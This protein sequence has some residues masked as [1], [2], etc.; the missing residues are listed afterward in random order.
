VRPETTLQVNTYP[1]VEARSAG[2]QLISFPANRDGD[3]VLYE[4]VRAPLDKLTPQVLE[5][6]GSEPPT[7]E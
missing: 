6:L 4:L 1:G 7:D 5:L 3:Y 2:G